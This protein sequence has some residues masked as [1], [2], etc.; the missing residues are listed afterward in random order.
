MKTI[1]GKVVLAATFICAALPPVSG[2]Q[3]D[4]MTFGYGA[5]GLGRLTLLP[6]PELTSPAR[7]F[8]KSASLAQPVSIRAVGE[9]LFRATTAEPTTSPTKAPSPG[10]E[11]L[12]FEFIVP[13]TPLSL[14]T[15]ITP[16][17]KR[18]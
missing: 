16:A 12:R 5:R 6:G 15:K 10:A 17:P 9:P 2:A 3:R 13:A 14:P 7:P 4:D 11:S 8:P 18:D 1:V